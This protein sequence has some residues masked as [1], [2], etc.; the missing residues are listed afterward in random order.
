MIHVFIELDLKQG[1]LIYLMTEKGEGFTG[2]YQNEY[3]SSK[4]TFTFSNFSNGK[5]ETIYID[6]LQELRR[7]NINN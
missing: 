2:T 4:E 1:E 5:E 7:L 6:R 3:N